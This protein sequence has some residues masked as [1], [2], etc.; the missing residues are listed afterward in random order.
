M[1]GLLRKDLYVLFQAS[2]AQLL[3]ALLF[4]GLSMATENLLMAYMLALYAGMTPLTVISLDEQSRFDCFALALPWS[5]A[6]I[7]LSKYILCFAAGCAAAAAYLL[8]TL[9]LGPIL[10]SAANPAEALATSCGMLTAGILLPALMLPLAFRFGTEKGRM[11][12]MLIMIAAILCI[13]VFVTDAGGGLFHPAGGFGTAPLWLLPL[14]ALALFALS[15]LVS[16]GIYK[17]RE[18]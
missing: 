3:I 6:Q 4:L 15:A 8:C 7:V 13:G 18:L 11:W 5:R 16:V 9:A 1:K 17:R 12:S 2:R 10:G 14:G